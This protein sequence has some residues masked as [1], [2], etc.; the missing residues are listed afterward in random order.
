M[1]TRCDK[2]GGLVTGRH[3]GFEAVCRCFSR[4]VKPKIIQARL[5]QRQN[6]DEDDIAEIVKGSVGIEIE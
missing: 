6:P 5:R 3:H 1:I 2:C 4:K